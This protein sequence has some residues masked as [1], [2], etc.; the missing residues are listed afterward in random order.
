MGNLMDASTLRAGETPEQGA[1]GA[2]EVPRDGKVGHLLSS[3][4]GRQ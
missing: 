3:C 2:G 4:L 1:G